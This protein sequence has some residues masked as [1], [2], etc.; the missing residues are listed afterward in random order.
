M[1]RPYGSVPDRNLRV[2]AGCD[3]PGGGSLLGAGVELLDLVVDCMPSPLDRP[4]VTGINPKKKD[5]EE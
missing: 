5:K 1:A 4:P 2:S 3:P